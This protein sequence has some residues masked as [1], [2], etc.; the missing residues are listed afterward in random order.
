MWQ[1]DEGQP[2]GPTAADGLL[3][4]VFDGGLKEHEEWE[5]AEEIIK[6]VGNRWLRS[7]DRLAHVTREAA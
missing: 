7:G 2:Q 6:M 5:G 3:S 4:A 1:R